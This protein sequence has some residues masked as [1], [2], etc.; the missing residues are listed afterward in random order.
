MKIHITAILVSA[1]T[2]LAAAPTAIEVSVKDGWFMVNGE[3]FFVKGIGYSVGGGRGGYP[4]DRTFDRE[5][6]EHDM[7]LMKA[8]GFN[9]VRAW[10]AYP[11]PELELLR[12]HGMMVIQGYWFAFKR[13]LEDEAYARQ[14]REELAEVVRTGKRFGNILF[15]TITNEPHT[16]DLLRAGLDS[17]YR[18]CRE[19]KAAAR[20]ED[21]NCR[22][23][24]SHMSAN[25]LLDQSMWDVVFFN[26]YMYVPNTVTA[27]LKYRGHVEWLMRRHGA[28]KKPFVIGEFGL[29][30]SPNGP[31]KM[32]Y[33]GNTLE[34]QRDGC[35]HMYQSII[36]AG[37]QGGCL[38]HWRDGWFKFGDPT[39]HSPHPE[40][41]Y[42][43]LGIKDEQS[44]PR[45][46]PRPVYYA[47]KE[48]NQVIVT[49][50]R[51]MV[52][53]PGVI[54]VRAFVT[55]KVT[56]VRCRLDE[57]AWVGMTKIGSSWWTADLDGATEGRHTVTIEARLQLGEPRAIVRCVELVA[58]DPK[59]AL[60]TLSLSADKQTYAYGE[61]ARVRVRSSTGDGAP[62]PRLEFV[63]TYQRH[64]N[65]EGRTFEG[66]TND[67]GL[68]ETSIPLFTKPTLVTLAV[69]A[70]ARTH[71]AL[72]RL[73]DATGIEVTGP[74]YAEIEEAAAHEGR[75]I[76]GFE[77]ETDDAFLAA[78]GRV[79][80]GAARYTVD[81]ETT[82]AKQGSAALKLRLEPDGPHSWGYT[83]I[84]FQ[85]PKDIS[86]DRAIS[87]WLHGDG[88]G[89][90]VKVMLID[91]DGERWLD[92]PVP[93][94]FR[95]WK[96]I[97]FSPRAV[98][99]DPYDGIKNGDGRPNPD[100]L[101]GL[102]FAM[103]S[104]SR[105]VSTILLD[106]IE[107]HE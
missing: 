33:G 17:Y 65:N 48:Y 103:T 28:G 72:H 68:Y 51:R 15:Y 69:G 57:G 31:G 66:T 77:Y 89:H 20:Q 100:R 41:W 2:A 37:A 56:S 58:G 93:I 97:I 105:K 18:A 52:V 101:A 8:A 55:K 54:P 73:T 83:E 86:G 84:F 40:E 71:G 13:Y 7:A 78:R 43:V 22:V 92:E 46:T 98:Q 85:S 82:K 53:Y 21:P 88:S 95:G 44:D 6:M 106:R 42:G 10:N 76:A 47:F 102:A 16:H 30:V 96:R 70:D 50:P 26:S 79:L 14:T 39:S 107:A 23:T 59:H 25:E 1:T 75:L 11:P 90:R 27:S 29:S 36:D 64:C 12:D 38:F 9:T 67:E 32:G 63:G 61:T 94:R 35:L 19:L 5:L 34:E 4:W 74:P 80:G 99:R 49:E 104:N 91:K 60:P 62:L 45:G 3:R 24:F 87:F 81:R